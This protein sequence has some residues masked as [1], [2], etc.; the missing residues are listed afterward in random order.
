MASSALVLTGNL[1]DKDQVPSRKIGVEETKLE[2]W[3][4]LNLLQFVEYTIAPGRSGRN[5]RAIFNQSMKWKHSNTP[6]HWCLMVHFLS[7][8]LYP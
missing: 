2:S 5:Q 1:V 4:Q 6:S 8:V 3:Y 7:S